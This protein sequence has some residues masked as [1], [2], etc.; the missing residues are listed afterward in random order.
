MSARPPRRARSASC[1]VTG[2]GEIPGSAAVLAYPNPATTTVNIY[3]GDLHVEAIEAIN[4]LG[5]TVQRFAPAA[6]GRH[7]ELDI[8]RWTPGV[9]TLRLYTAEGVVERRVVKKG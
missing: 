5:Q 4:A 8:E 6:A 9:Y 1:T 7:H 2:A 3:S